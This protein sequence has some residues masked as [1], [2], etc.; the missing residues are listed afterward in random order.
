LD[1][2]LIPKIGRPNIDSPPI[3]L[4]KITVIGDYLLDVASRCSR[5][6]MLPTSNGGG[7]MKRLFLLG[8][9]ALFA[10]A[11]PKA[12]AAHRAA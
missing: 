4:R 5:D 11:A 6:V 1:I 3:A 2:F 7:V 12:S 9:I 8:I 10:I